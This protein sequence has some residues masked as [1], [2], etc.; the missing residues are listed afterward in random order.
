MKS[1]KEME[2]LKQ[3]LSVKVREIQS[4]EKAQAVIEKQVTELREKAKPE[5][6]YDRIQN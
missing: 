5:V 3:K 1:D 4:S 2:E 6:Y